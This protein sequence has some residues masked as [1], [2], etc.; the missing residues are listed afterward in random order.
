M[1]T[2]ENQIYQHFKES[3]Q[4]FVSQTLDQINQVQTTHVPL[5]TAFM[6]PRERYILQTLVNSFDDSKYAE[7]EEFAKFETTRAIIYPYY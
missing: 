7:H 5:L 4:E 1:A 2:P 6:N 3:E